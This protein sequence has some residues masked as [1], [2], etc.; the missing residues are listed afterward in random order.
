MTTIRDLLRPAFKKLPAGA[1]CAI[2]RAVN[3]YRDLT[4]GSYKNWNELSREI[5]RVEWQKERWS[6]TELDSFSELSKSAWGGLQTLGYAMVREYR[7]RIVVELG[8]HMGLSALAMGMALRDLGEGGKLYAVDTWQGDQHA[9]YSNGDEIYHTFL[10]RC[11]SLGLIDV[12]IPLRMMFHEARDRI[13][14][15]ID[16]LHIDGEHTWD[17]VS[18]DFDTYL[19][20][21][22]HGGIVMFHDVNTYHDD[23]RRFWSAV[24][25][26]YVSHTIPYSHGLGII[27][28]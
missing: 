16:M 1:R 8:T 18:R 28:V 2:R 12:I 9:S 23:V 17:A 19:P 27:R 10:N 11:T 4:H 15:K 22:R 14:G 25:A 5:T 3:N 13:L 24:S 21:V 26:R 20:L 7:P 6:L